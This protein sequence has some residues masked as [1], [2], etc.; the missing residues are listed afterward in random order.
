MDTLH[1]DIDGMSCGHCVGAVKQALAALD[2]VSVDAVTVGS[3][4]LRHDPT[5][6]ST[7][8]ILEA[9]TAAGYP[10]HAVGSRQ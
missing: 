4:D 10:A 6:S 8:A 3:A 7:E 5:K 1:L 2:G 9:V